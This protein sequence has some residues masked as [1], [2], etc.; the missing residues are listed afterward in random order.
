MNE[1]ER[2]TGFQWDDGNSDKNWVAHQVSRAECEEFF[3]NRPLVVHPDPR[4]SSCE[5]RYYALG[6]SDSGRT[7]FI[8]FTVRGDLVRVIS[9]RDMSRRERSV[10]EESK[11]R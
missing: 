8:V 9:A 2:S 10:Y 6:H 1:L 3:F 11:E 5:V 4:H 7:L